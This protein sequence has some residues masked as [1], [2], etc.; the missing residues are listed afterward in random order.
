MAGV[1]GE[2]G[3]GG[4]EPSSGQAT[5]VPTVLR[6][7]IGRHKQR[8]DT[9]GERLCAG[10]IPVRRAP[11]EEGGEMQVLLVSSRGGKGFGLPKVRRTPVKSGNMQAPSSWAV[12]LG[13]DGRSVR[14][15]GW[16]DDE[17]VEDAARRETIEEAG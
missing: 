5:E 13:K 3:C 15:G 12:E 9:G 14:V 17:S 1:A 16:E 7:R 8:F 2:N 11:L 4:M 6:A 10:C